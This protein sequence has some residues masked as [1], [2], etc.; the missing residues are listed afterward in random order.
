MRYPDARRD[1]VTERRHRHL[2][3]DP[4]RWLEDPDSEDTRRWLRE[5]QALSVG[6]LERLPGRRRL[7]AML[8]DLAPRPSPSPARTA[9]S[10]G[11]RA[12]PFGPDERWTLQVRERAGWRTVVG[13]TDLHPHA[14]VASWQP[15]PAGSLVA[16]QVL[17]AGAEDRTPLSLVD[18]TTGRVVET[19]SGTR[20]SPIEWRADE[21]AYFCARGHLDR[22][23]TGVYHHKIGGD[24][25]AD[26]L[27]AGDEAATTRYHVALWHDRWLVVTV[28]DGTARDT[29]VSVA[30]V[31]AGGPLR[32]LPPGAGASAVVVV[33]DDDR[34][35]A[36]SSTAGGFG[37]V[38]VADRAGDGWGPWRVLLP[39]D[40]SGVLAGVTLARTERGR[41]LVA[42]RNRDGVSRMTVHDATTGA[43]LTE[44]GLPGDGTV[45][46]I[47]PTGD[48]A[49]LALT[50]AG[51]DTP[52]SAWRLDVRSGRVTPCDG[53][54]ARPDVEVSRHVYHSADGTEVPLTILA[55]C[56]AERPRPTLLAV[57][58]GFGIP[59]RP[60]FQPDLLAWV[61]NGGYVAV[62][63]I[64]GGGERGRRWHQEGSGANKGNAL[65]DLH[66]AGDWLVRHGWTRRDQLALL[67][68]S[69]G[70]LLAMAAAVQRPEAYAVV[71]C[72]GAPFDMIRYERWGLGEAWRE[73]YG[74][75][76]EPA[77]LEALLSY[78]P[79]HNVSAGRRHPATILITGSNDTRVDPLHSR[80]MAAQLQHATT[81]GP[82]LHYVVEGAGHT[83]A[84]GEQGIW[85]TA[86]A[87]AFIARHTGLALADDG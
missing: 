65:A 32:P 48:P 39:E 66:A 53:A 72:A 67:G 6:C 62:A 15:S 77:G 36:S 87:L 5:Q 34:L 26:E 55:G 21:Q 51:W 43:A 41:R 37:Q 44:V 59:A 73:E 16:I 81:G 84:R 86:A 85:K 64:R 22:P 75:P 30:D 80:K 38:L 31:R 50:Y 9:G 58:G 76:D 18:V 69:N 42:L 13:V 45:S 20:Y 82:V 68:G 57:Y 47:R 25:T 60:S 49:V 74:S 23:G 83:G 46:S 19:V 28:R 61:L 54:P 4:Y 1:P 63:G 3:A 8:R 24:V 79:Y 40:T 71:G 10:R 14:T 2:V 29:R 33:D 56:G 12:G 70:G 27:V 11:F 78:S 17:V 52:P 35:V 7:S